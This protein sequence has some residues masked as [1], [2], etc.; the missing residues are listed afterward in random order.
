MALLSGCGLFK[1]ADP[2]KESVNW[3]DPAPTPSGEAMTETVSPTDQTSESSASDA[4]ATKWPYEILTTETPTEIPDSSSS[5]T[6]IPAESSKEPAP[7]D[8]PVSSTAAPTESSNEAGTEKPT[9]PLTEKPTETY[10]TEAA[11]L[12]SSTEAPTEKPT[13]ADT[14]AAPTAAPTEAPTQKPTEAPTAAQ[15]DPPAADTSVPYQTVFGSL[16]Q[17]AARRFFPFYYNL[18][19][20]AKQVYNELAEAIAAGQAAVQIRAASATMQQAQQALRAIANDQ[21]QF[22]WFTGSGDRISSLGSVVS[23]EFNYLALNNPTAKSAF[24]SALNALVGAVNGK[25]AIEK[26]RYF[27]DTLINSVTYAHNSF[28]QSAYSALVQHQ[29]VC[30]GYTRAF[31]AACM[32]AGIPC[33]YC[34][35]SGTNPQGNQE[36]HA[37]NIIQLD[38]AYYNIDLT[39]DDQQNTIFY[40]YYNCTDAEF[41]AKHSRDGYGA[42]LPACT[43][44]ARSFRN[45][46]G[47]TP[48]IAGMQNL[49]PGVPVVNSLGEYIE[50]RK[51]ALNT[52]CPGT[53]V[54]EVLIPSAVLYQEI[55]NHLNEGITDYIREIA[56]A[57]GLNGF[58]F[59][60]GISNSYFPE[61]SQTFWFRE[62]LTVE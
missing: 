35:G 52:A 49:Y 28:D 60:S 34:S 3:T 9:E 5:G 22:F 47:V 29:A 13:D 55:Q 26:E 1:P 40:H 57:K 18:D 25:S 15:T 17:S 45:C 59:S 53:A 24:T 14:T 62:S 31:Q 6:E 32:A 37:W 42:E 16:D 12:A 11:T 50:L 21:P 20:T 23:V 39:W 30:A 19:D 2:T 4:E 41:S 36:S 56:A 8:E 58:A 10:S 44:T 51:A 33:Y 7:T 43:S 38:G 27:H 61:D 46:F 48:G 54:I